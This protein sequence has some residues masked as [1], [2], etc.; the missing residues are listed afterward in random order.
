VEFNVERLRKITE[1][2]TQGATIVIFLRKIQIVTVG[3][4]FYDAF[5]LTTLCGG[6][7]IVISE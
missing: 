2:F 1:N 7:D 5:S 3:S 6:D 4:L